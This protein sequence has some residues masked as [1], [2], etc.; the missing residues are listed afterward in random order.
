MPVAAPIACGKNQNYWKSTTGNVN[1]FY[2]V[3]IQGADAVLAALR[4]GEIDA[5]DPMYEVGTLAN[6]IDPSWATLISLRQQQV[7]ANVPQ[8]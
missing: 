5:H 8:P 7:A 4:S 1:D 3:N 2:V 6:T